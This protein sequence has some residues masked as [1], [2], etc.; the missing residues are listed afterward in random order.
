[1]QKIERRSFQNIL[2]RIVNDRTQTKDNPGLD[3]MQKEFF[4]V[5][6]DFYQPLDRSVIQD[7]FS[8]IL[9]GGCGVVHHHSR[10]FAPIETI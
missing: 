5:F 10:R 9:N 3:V 1:M 2:M 7:D 6:D 4:T 8:G